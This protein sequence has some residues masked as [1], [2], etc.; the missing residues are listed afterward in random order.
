M[1]LQ[2]LGDQF[3]G[4]LV[5]LIL[6]GLDLVAGISS[7]DDLAVFISFFVIGYLNFDI[8]G[9]PGCL[10]DN[11]VLHFYV[12]VF[13]IGTQKLD[14]NITAAGLCFN[15]N[16]IIGVVLEAEVRTV[17]VDR[18]VHAKGHIGRNICVI[19][20][21]ND[22][23]VSKQ[24]TVI[25]GRRGL[26]DTATDRVYGLAA[27]IGSCGL[28][29]LFFRTLAQSL[30]VVKNITGIEDQSVDSLAG[31]LQVCVTVGAASGTG[32][33]GCQNIPEQKT[34][35][36]LLGYGRSDSFKGEFQFITGFCGG[37]CFLCTFQVKGIAIDV[38][39]NLKGLGIHHCIYC[40]CAILVV[41]GIDIQRL[42]IDLLNGGRVCELVLVDLSDHSF[43]DRIHIQ[44]VGKFAD[45]DLELLRFL[46]CS[47]FSAILRTFCRILSD[48]IDY[49]P[50]MLDHFGRIDG[51]QLQKCIG[52]AILIQTEVRTKFDYSTCGRIFSFVQSKSGIQNRFHIHSGTDRFR[53]NG[54]NGF[55]NRND[56]IF[57]CVI[58]LDCLGR[59]GSRFFTLKT[60]DIHTGNRKILRRRFGSQHISK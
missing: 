48:F 41:D 39:G 32:G 46:R 36:G 14:G 56:H 24:S 20:A 52:D 29:A 47:V 54:D 42:R 59:C 33:V 21:L 49:F 1:G 12:V 37:E 51:F 2:G 57:I 23:K 9:F 60:A 55:T 45:G 27:N 22:L 5:I 50:G 35:K 28:V 7:G 44:S 10:F 13:F 58:I 34:G 8:L 4:F 17:P 11:L 43:A 3:I 31:E 38:I 19:M 18:C 25:D 30:V 26:A 6:I 16:G 40:L 53:R 15:L